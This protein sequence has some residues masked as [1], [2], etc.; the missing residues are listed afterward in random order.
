MG[1]CMPGKRGGPTQKQP[2]QL[3]RVRLPR[4]RLCASPSGQ[5]KEI[6]PPP[7]Q[8]QAQE[9]GGT[10]RGTEPVLKAKKASSRGRTWSRARSAAAGSSAEL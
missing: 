1:A 3:P 10:A 7:L 2:C 9:Q 4:R 6:E 5:P 8:F